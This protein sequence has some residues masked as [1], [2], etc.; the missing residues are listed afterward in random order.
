M[1][2]CMIGLLV[3]LTFDWQ[4]QSPTYFAALL[5]AWLLP[6][7]LMWMYVKLV[8]IRSRQRALVPQDVC[9][10]RLTQSGWAIGNED[11]VV[12]FDWRDVLGIYDSLDFLGF[13]TINQLLQLSS[14]KDLSRRH[15]KASVFCRRHWSCKG[16]PI[17]K[18]GSRS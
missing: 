18:T 8:S 12:L 9:K 13:K 1:I 17:A 3:W 10:L 11:G 5:A 7:G 14:Q 6:L 16:K 4:Q 15:G 2:G